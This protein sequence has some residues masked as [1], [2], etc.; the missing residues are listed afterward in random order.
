MAREFI[1]KPGVRESVPLFVGLVGPSSSGKT[2]SA[3]RMAK[4][5]DEIMKRPG[6]I[7][8]IDTENRRGLHYA[9][10]FSY[11]H[12]QFGAPYASLDYLAAVRYAQSLNPSVIVIDSMSHEHEGPG[13]MLDMQEK[14]VDRMAGPNASYGKRHAVGFTAWAKPK[15]HRRQFLT[16]LMESEAAII[17]CFRGQEK[18]KP[19]KNDKG[20][21]EPTNIGW[22]AIADANMVFEMAVCALLKPGA[23][24]VPDWNPEM[25]AE[26]TFVKRPGW[27]EKL[28]GADQQ[29][30]EDHGRALAE[31][32]KGD[33]ARP[34]SEN[35]DLEGLKAEGSHAASLGM[36]ALTKFWK[37][38]SRQ[39]QVSLSNTKDDHWKP[40]AVAAD[41]AAKGQT[42]Q[43]FER[44]FE[45]GIPV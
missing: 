8:M 2:Y 10:E 21:M 31:W 44:E 35:T 41:E 38:L 33:V 3:L 16:G 43:S 29:L 17:A 42:E 9:N 18:T 22:Q 26:R 23:K 30:S 19:M 7:V 1:A 45:D 36:E 11:S 15:L 37:G 13:G 32:A 40:T 20:K 14:E 4:G 6:G 24:G 12:V 25:P 34:K 28:I 27:A 39:Q 5:M